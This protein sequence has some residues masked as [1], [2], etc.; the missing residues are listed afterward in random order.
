[1]SRYAIDE[2]MMGTEWTWGAQ[3]LAAFADDLRRVLGDD[4]PEVVVVLDGGAPGDQDPNLVS[5]GQ[6]MAALDAFLLREGEEQ[7]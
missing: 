6:W 2:A 1:M 4:G 3:G 7:G 5:E